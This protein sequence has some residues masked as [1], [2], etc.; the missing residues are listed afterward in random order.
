[1]LKRHLLAIS[2][3]IGMT[4]VTASASIVG[5]AFT[6]VD[7]SSSSALAGYVTQDLE[8]TTSGDDWTAAALLIE[9]TSGSIY[10][11]GLGNADGT[12][13]NPALFGLAPSLAF[14]TYVGVLGG[15]GNTVAGGA[16]DLGG[17]PALQFDTAGLNVSWANTA[18]GDTGT[19]TIGRF[20]LSSDASGTWS[21]GLISQDMGSAPPVVFSGAIAGGQLVPEPTTLVV[22]ALGSTA[23]LGRRR[24]STHHA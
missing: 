19:T 1:M 2:G 20:S 12:P 5:H 23:L 6:S 24:M 13:P 22:L 21:L 15:L 9:L 4:A 7:N 11:D 10:Q 14:D 17:N 16:A 18:T 3:A 8:V